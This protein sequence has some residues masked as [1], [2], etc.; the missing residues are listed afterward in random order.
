MRS[1]RPSA[2]HYFVGTQGNNFFY[3]DPHE[4]RRALPFCE[5]VEAYELE[6]IQSCHTR[7]LRRIEI[8][9]MDPS[10]LISFLIRDE[11][12]WRNWKKGVVSVQGKAIVHVAQ[13]EPPP[14]PGVE[15]EEAIDEV[16]S[17]DE[18]DDEM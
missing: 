17:F 7:R 18:H 13:S 5:D 12:D 14:H 6:D 10:M 2:S 1:G 9:E 8:R 15:R 11:A 4:T 3:L 16:E